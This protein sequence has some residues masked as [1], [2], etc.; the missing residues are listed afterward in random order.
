MELA[1]LK[2]KS[3]INVDSFLHISAQDP[4]NKDLV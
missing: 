3:I 1:G 4:Y 2:L